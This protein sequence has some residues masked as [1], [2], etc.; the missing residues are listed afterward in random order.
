[1]YRAAASISARLARLMVEMG[2]S[3]VS[4]S[5]CNVGC[6][7][8]DANQLEGRRLDID[9]CTLAVLDVSPSTSTGDSR[10]YFERD[11]GRWRVCF[12]FSVVSLRIP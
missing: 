12:H 7:S 10:L 11:Y 2:E 4:V 6:F 9:G 3:V 1:M 5:T 8:V